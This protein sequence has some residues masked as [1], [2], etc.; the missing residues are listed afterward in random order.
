MII[1]TAS[2]ITLTWMTDVKRKVPYTVLSL[3]IAAGLTAE[4]FADRRVVIALSIA[5]SLAFAAG[6][7]TLG[8]IQWYSQLHISGD[9]YV[10]SVPQKSKVK[11]IYQ[12]KNKSIHIESAKAAK[13]LKKRISY[14]KSGS[15][16]T[17]VL[18][19]NVPSGYRVVW[20]IYIRK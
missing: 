6:T 13:Y 12:L 5:S 16:K 2:F 20:T 15:S 4:S 9:R 1:L 18:S 19:K 17:A 3:V 8:R 10:L 14:K 7:Y 11:S